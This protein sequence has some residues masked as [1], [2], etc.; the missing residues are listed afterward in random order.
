[1][2]VILALTVGIV[3]QAPTAPATSADVAPVNPAAEE[4]APQPLME[5]PGLQLYGVVIVEPGIRLAF[6][7]DGSR[8]G[9]LRKVREGQT[10]AGAL[11]KAIHPDRVILVSSRGEVSLLLRAK[12]DGSPA[13]MAS[14]ADD[15]TS[16]PA[17]VVSEPDDRSPQPLRSSD[18][19]IPLITRQPL[20]PQ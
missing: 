14:K 18:L 6:I 20:Y 3:L 11:V 4:S 17:G 9:Q 12:K 19:S 2:M 1:M 16:S 13:G 7:Q 15:M 10:V 8:R 5:M